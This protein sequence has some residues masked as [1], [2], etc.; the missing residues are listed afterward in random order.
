MLDPSLF[1]PARLRVLLEKY[2]PEGEMI[3]DHKD[4][5][6]S[7]GTIWSRMVP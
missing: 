4:G 7:A 1:S 3:P 6:K 2:K 5:S